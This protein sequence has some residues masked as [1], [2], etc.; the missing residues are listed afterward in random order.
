MTDFSSSDWYK[1]THSGNG[2]NCVEVAQAGTAIG[3]RD[4]KDPSGPVLAFTGPEWSAFVR[5]VKD[6]EFDLNR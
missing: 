3:V 5:G 2:G 1:S 4:S 6:G